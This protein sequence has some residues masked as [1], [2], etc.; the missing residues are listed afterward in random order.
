[1]GVGAAV[2]VGVGE[3]TQEQADDTF[4][5]LPQLDANVGM[6]VTAVAVYVGQT[7]DAEADCRITWRRQL[8]WLQ[9]GATTEAVVVGVVVAFLYSSKTTSEP[10]PGQTMTSS[11]RT[12][13]RREIDPS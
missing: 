9:V 10:M 11:C 7:A 5:A 8:S 6:L 1:V 12:E 4:A 13:R 2:E 3:T